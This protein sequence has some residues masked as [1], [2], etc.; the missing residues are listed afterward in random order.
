M[1]LNF[2]KISLFLSSKI[3]KKNVKGLNQHKSQSHHNGGLSKTK[4]LFICDRCDTGHDFRTA[5]MLLKHYLQVIKSNYW[6]EEYSQC[7]DL[8]KYSLYILCRLMF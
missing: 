6:I 7:F 8:Q 3:E 1:I 4:V 5:R 2:F